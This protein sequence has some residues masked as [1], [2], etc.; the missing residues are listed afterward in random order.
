MPGQRARLFFRRHWQRAVQWREKLVLKEEAFHL[1][2]AGI[3][4]I[5]GGLVNVFFYYAGEMV[6][7]IFMMQP[8]DPAEEAQMFA[9]LQRLLVPTF[10]GLAAGL[11]LHW[12]LRIVGK[13]GTSDL[14]EVVVAGDGRLPLRTQLVKTASAL[15]SIVSGA[16]IGREGGIVQ[17][18]ATVASKLGQWAK[19]PPYRLRLLVGCG[20]SAGIAS[21]YNAPIAGAVFAALIVL[22]NF[23]MSLFAPLV[24]ASVMATMTSRTFF[25]IEPWYQVPKFP[26]ITAINLPWF[27]LMGI[28]C[29]GGAALFLKLL[30]VISAQ[31]EKTR[32]PI[33]AKLTLAGLVV[34]V[35]AMKLPGVCGNGYYVTNNILQGGYENNPHAVPQLSGLFLF[36]LLATVIVVGAGT[37]GGVFTPTLF[38]GATIGALFGV[39]I[40]GFYGAADLPIGAFA[41]VGMGATLAGTTKS[42]LLAII[43]AFEI[44]LDYSLMP[45]LMLACVISVLV[46]RQFH[47]ES[48]Y[49]EHMRL[50]GLSLARESEQTGAAMDKTIGDLMQAPV[51]P[52]RE[53]TTLRE[54]AERFLGSPNNFV[55]I[56]D[57]EKR[58]IGIVALH[59]LKEFLNSTQNLGGVIAYDL[60]RPVPKCLTPGQRLLDALPI[61]LQSEIRNV[62]VV[63]N[64]KENRLVGSVSR[65]EVLAIFSEAIAEK[66][67]PAG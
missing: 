56:V 40:H 43:M 14:L 44:S 12:G 10:G 48:I 19:W 55:P 32:L 58:F 61:V 30:R 2:L 26:D 59:D 34:G 47:A 6:Q 16:S 50:K 63:N 13:Q 49:T 60:M 22:G 51:P 11:I 25:G 18:S 24:C 3:V 52:L 8:G 62:P 36:K 17:L 29:G 46:A 38:L 7:R 53:T 67:K 28:F 20:A 27:L 33:Y 35:I 23:S 15:M 41:L 21:V 5:L 64:P 4:G 37:V 66:S 45:A 65:A 31:F 39:V 54:I 57:A 42:P 1:I 9:P